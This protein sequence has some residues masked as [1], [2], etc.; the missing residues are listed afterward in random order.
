MPATGQTASSSLHRSTARDSSRK[1]D[2]QQHAAGKQPMLCWRVPHQVEVACLGVMVRTAKPCGRQQ[3]RQ[4]TVSYPCAGSFATVTALR[5]APAQPRAQLAFP[6][7][8]RRCVLYHAVGR[9]MNELHLV[10]GRGVEH[11]HVGVLRQ[12]IGAVD[13]GGGQVA[14]HA[15]NVYKLA[16][17]SIA[18][19]LTS[20]TIKFQRPSRGAVGR[21]SNRQQALCQQKPLVQVVL[22]NISARAL[23]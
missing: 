18:W 21:C 20:S 3:M 11:L 23:L 19:T 14:V 15:A 7:E 5:M 2:R 17:L 8:C 16:D 4:Q 22:S 9:S 6:T 12:H 1:A 10:D 13:V